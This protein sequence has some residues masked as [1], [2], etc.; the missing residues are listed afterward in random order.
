MDQKN[1]WVTKEQLVIYWV[2]SEEW[3]T[4]EGKS[5]ICPSMSGVVQ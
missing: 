4:S 5:K 1:L 2:F 3:W